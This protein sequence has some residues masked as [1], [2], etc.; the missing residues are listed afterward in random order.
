V[1]LSKAVELLERFELSSAA[2]H[3]HV[4]GIPETW[5]FGLIGSETVTLFR[6]R[7]PRVVYNH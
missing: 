7:T 4:S 6:F 5:K 2:A 1:E 3:F